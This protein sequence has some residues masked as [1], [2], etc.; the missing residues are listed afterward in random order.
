[1]PRKARALILLFVLL[2]LPA[3]GWG[4]QG[5]EI[6]AHIAAR[7]LSPRARA[8]VSALL[9]G[10]AE[11]MM[12]TQAN[13]ADEIRDARPQTTRWHFVNIPLGAAGFDPRRDCPG[14]DCVVVQIET[15]LRILADRKR[16]RAARAEALRFLIHFVGDI[17]QPL[18]AIDNHDRGGNDVKVRLAPRQTPVNLHQ[19]WDTR[20]LGAL[21]ASDAAIL[22]TQIAAPLSAS[23]KASWRSGAAAR[24]A[25]ESARLAAQAIYPELGD[26]RPG[27]RPILLPRDYLKREAPA[28]RAQLARAG[29]R[30]GWLLNTALQ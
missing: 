20:V 8:E 13:W 26:Y 12:V 25:N 18:H 29:V 21:P 6:V 3:L 19:V 15:D 22:A 14:G 5:H 16:S 30:L 23:A 4:P 28:V 17:H 10:D 7:E 11:A 2:P 1:M 27:G 24:W 9:G